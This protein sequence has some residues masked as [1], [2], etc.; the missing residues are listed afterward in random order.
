MAQPPSPMALVKRTR[1]EA[2]AFAEKAGHAN[3]LKLLAKAQKELEHRLNQTPGLVHAAGE[4]FS[5][6]RMQLVLKQV[7]AVTKAL[8]AAMKGTLTD[9]GRT[10]AGKAAKDTADFMQAAEKRFRGISAVLPINVASMVDRAV[11]GSESSIL[12][13]I[14]GD[15]DHKG[16]PGVLARYGAETITKFEERLQLGLVQGKRWEEVRDDLTSESEFLQGA[17]KYWAERIVRTETLH[18]Y[19]RAAHESMK[20]TQ[21]VLGDVVKILVATFD[22]RTGWD[23][24]QVHGQIRRPEEPFEWSKGS[25][26]YPPNRPND[27]ETTITYRISWP[28][29]AELEPMSDGE[30]EDRYHEQYPK[31]PG[32]GERPNMSTVDRELFGVQEP[33]EVGEG[34]LAE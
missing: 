31:G 17:P 8:T 11:S 12:H 26:M 32:P 3:V 18:S 20:Q 24:Y 5:V 15:P 22:D 19:N 1:A 25:Y 30:V 14:E 34:L 29:E 21:E 23:S 27:R 16:R 7:Q 6:V 33:P 13:R 9:S 2:L 10:V 4:P 28:L